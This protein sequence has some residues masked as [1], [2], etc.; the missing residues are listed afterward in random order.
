MRVKKKLLAVPLLLAAV[1]VIGLSYPCTESSR[2]AFVTA[3][4][5]FETTHSSQSQAVTDIAWHLAKRPEPG[6]MD[7]AATVFLTIKAKEKI[8]PD[9]VDK[10]NMKKAKPKNPRAHAAEKARQMAELR[11]KVRK[12]KKEGFDKGET[13]RKVQRKPGEE[14]RLPISDEERKM[15]REKIEGTGV[16]EKEVRATV[17]RLKGEIPVYRKLREC[18][19]PEEFEE[20]EVEDF[21]PGKSVTVTSDAYTL[22]YEGGMIYTDARGRP[23]YVINITYPDDTTKKYWTRDKPSVIRDPSDEHRNLMVDFN[24]KEGTVEFSHAKKKPPK[25]ISPLEKLSL[26]LDWIIH[27]GIW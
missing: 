4:P 27:G 8:P 6:D 7:P 15:Q 13:I 23:Y 1:A 10:V 20:P 11:K 16:T 2:M 26:Y 18:D 25:T 14:V 5:E 17:V 22:K 9:E 19:S 3:S 21:K 24:P 12:A